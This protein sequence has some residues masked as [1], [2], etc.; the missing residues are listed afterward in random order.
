MSPVNDSTA[1]R[2][3]GS[4]RPGFSFDVKLWKVSKTGRKS[5]P[6][7]L[8]WVVAGRVHGDT[9]TTSALAESRRSELWQAMNRRGEAFEID[10]GLPE[11]E[12]RAAAQAAEAAEAVPPVRWFEF[13]RKYVAGRWRTSAAKTR[14]G[15]ADGLAAVTLAMV[16]RG[17]GVPDD[18]LLRLGFRWAIVPANAG[19]DPPAELKAA[20]DWLTTNDLRLADVADAEVF[21][22][23]MY[24]VSYKLDG[25]P[26][27]GDTYKR[28]RRALNA[29]LEH[30]VAVGELPENPLQRSRKKRVGSNDVVDRRVLVNPVQARQ[31][32]TAVSYV[33]SWD[34][35]R[36]RRLV[37][38]Y[39][40]LYYA[41]LRPAEAVGLRLSDCHLPDKD[42]G[43]L[44]LRETRP[45]SGKQWTDSGER[46]DRRGL[47]AREASTD[48]PVP[49]PPVLVAV[50][51]A[52]LN[53]F[54][55]AMEGRVFGNERGGVVGSS[56]YWRVWE[57][58]REYAL[59]PERV[60]SPLA[61]RPYDLRH[62]CITRWLNAGVP[63]AE[64]ARRVG[65]SPEV[66][67][68]RY[69]GCIDGHE[70]IANARIAKALEEE[71]DGAI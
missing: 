20:Y 71:G 61:G 26:A 23:V 67:H 51:R 25:T 22:G 37:A 70:E 45:V 1:G 39:A 18:E 58:A 6:W 60:A 47:K 34:R 29:A 57:E 28:R 14:E 3:R 44:T 41:G 4:A 55:T 68:R 30:A 33:G 11:S 8:R 42:W 38:F 59:P 64:V 54:G 53:E 21:E 2:T 12:V 17:E 15:V 13:C 43:T 16:K 46:H 27:A 7:R 49:I 50:L 24:R 19:E 66:I 36:G 31:L 5:R 9:F 63:I 10:S 40:V 52:H 56:T 62:A 35:C 48:R 65:N 69:H 32:L